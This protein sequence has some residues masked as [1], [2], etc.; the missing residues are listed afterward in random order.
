MSSVASFAAGGSGLF[1]GVYLL[2][3]LAVAIL[4]VASLWKIFVKAGKPGWAAIIP[5]YN[6]VVLLEIVGRPIWWVVLYFIP[7]AQLVVTI[8][9]SIDLARVFG[10]GAG[11]G[12]GLWLLW[13]VFYPILG[14][15][16]A[17]FVGTGAG[18]GLRRAGRFRALCPA[19]R[20][21]P[22]D[23]AT[24][25]SYGPPVGGSSYVPPTTPP[26]WAATAAPPAPPAPPQ[27]SSP[28]PPPPPP[29]P[30]V[31]QAPPAP[32]AAPWHRRLPNRLRRRFLRQHRPHR[33][34]RQRRPHR[35][36]RQHRRH[37]LR[38]PLR[39]QRRRLPRRLPRRPRRPLRLR[40]RRPLR[41]QRRRLPPRP[42]RRR[43]NPHRTRRRSRRR[44]SRPT[45]RLQHRR[46]HPSRRSDGRL[47]THCSCSGAESSS[48][49]SA[50]LSS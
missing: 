31:E 19:G 22:Y 17:R 32:P 7:I 23:P 9:V 50:P 36:L 18:A 40:P 35:L 47:L 43:R 21:A 38:Q 14:F 10:K 8:I 28:P 34:L 41:K 39:K 27:A 45:Q 15:G 12:I 29:A 3:W 46:R 5:I 42:L 11:F 44:P 49:L 48:E 20:Q 30:P 25:T 13:F 2:I 4:Y 6:L 16:E 24:G 1:G 26:P 37:R 33:L